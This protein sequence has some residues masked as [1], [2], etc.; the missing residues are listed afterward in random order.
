[1]ADKLTED[2]KV[3]ILEKEAVIKLHTIAQMIRCIDA[4]CSRGSFKGEEM[5]F[6]GQLRDTLNAGINKATEMFLEEREASKKES[7]VVKMDKIVEM[8][9]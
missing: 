6:V 1:M 8:D 9:E 4:S 2:E 3:K 5:S 7:K